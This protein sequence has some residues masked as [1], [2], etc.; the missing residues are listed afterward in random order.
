MTRRKAMDKIEY[1]G[2]QHNDA[3]VDDMIQR[4]T[5]LTQILQETE[6]FVDH[7]IRHEDGTSMTSD[8]KLKI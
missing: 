7:A 3:L 4:I 6:D 2:D 5:I 1:I 8:L